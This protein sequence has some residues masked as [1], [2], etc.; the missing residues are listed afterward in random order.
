[1]P[2]SRLLA[3]YINDDGPLLDRISESSPVPTSILLESSLL[4]PIVHF[5][6]LTPLTNSTMGIFR[7]ASLSRPEGEAGKTWPAIAM[8]F[9]VAF[10]GVLFG[11]GMMMSLL[12]RVS[13][14]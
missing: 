10:G 14:G 9:F 3:L 2:L 5:L 8:G 4:I 12:R 6:I 7:R 13:Q 11:Y 1:M